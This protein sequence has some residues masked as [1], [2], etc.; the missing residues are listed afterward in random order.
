MIISNQDLFD[1]DEVANARAYYN[2]KKKEIDAMK[3][4]LYDPHLKATYATQYQIDDYD[5]DGNLK[6]EA[7][8][9]HN[10]EIITHNPSSSGIEYTGDAARERMAQEKRAYDDNLR[11]DER[12][13]RA[14][15]E[16]RWYFAEKEEKAK[17]RKQL[18]KDINKYNDQVDLLNMDSPQMQKLDNR[19]ADLKAKIK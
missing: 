12:R 19:I 7:N 11:D 14:E 4:N 10:G 15:A 6:P 18:Q 13:A 5:K 3:D 1:A 16:L 2:N 8:I 17:L 9:E